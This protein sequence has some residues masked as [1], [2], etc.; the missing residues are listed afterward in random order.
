[1]QGKTP[2][3]DTIFSY[4]EEKPLRFHYPG[5]KGKLAPLDL[6]EIPQTDNLFTPKGPLLEAQRLIAVAFGADYSYFLVNG[7]TQGIHAAFLSSFK[8]GDKVLI[9][10]FS[11]RSIIEGLILAGLEPVFIEEEIDQW[12]IPQNIRLK[13]LDRCETHQVRGIVVTNPNY[14]GLT[15]DLSEIVQYA[16]ARD[17]I[18]IVDEAHGAHLHFNKKL[19]PS[20]LDV[21]A[22]ITVQS[23]HKMGISLTQGAVI[24]LKGKRIDKDILLDNVLFFSTTSPST[25]ILGSIDL[26]RRI[27]ALEGEKRLDIL[28]SI[29]E[30][31]SWKIERIGFP[32]YNKPNMDR[33]KLVLYNL[34]GEILSKRLWD[35]FKIQVE[36]SSETYCLLILSILDSKRSLK[37]LFDALK[38]ID[39]PPP[40]GPVIPPRYKL[41]KLPRRAYLSRKKRISLKS[42]VG[43]VSGEIVTRY[44]PGIPVLIPGALITYEIRDYLLSMGRDHVLISLD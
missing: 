17:M 12:G 15:S 24:H 11:H 4:I 19:P 20:G 43:K 32:V 5:H 27:L 38:K 29:I 37:R 35:G 41:V 2:Y 10:Y 7:S 3:L 28:L 36:I 25:V 8:E 13:D 34:D 9:P 21:G 16:H 33:T 40:R 30:E 42:A 26:G 31:F 18:V 44:P 22:D 1:M 6:T 39:L 14:F 23:M